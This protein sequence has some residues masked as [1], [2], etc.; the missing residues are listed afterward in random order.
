MC[1]KLLYTVALCT[2]QE[3]NA[4]GG[5][6]KT[7]GRNVKNQVVDGQQEVER[8]DQEKKLS[9]RLIPSIQEVLAFPDD[10]KQTPRG[11]FP[12]TRRK[13]VNFC[14]NSM[15]INLPFCVSPRYLTLLHFSALTFL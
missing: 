11:S 7:T 15:D 4:S 3:K 8:I 2:S 9:E 1:Y 14:V 13:G 6:D 5:I 10:D 12:C